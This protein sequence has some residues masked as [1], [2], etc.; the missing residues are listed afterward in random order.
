MIQQQV[1]K[2]GNS[3]V[4]TIPKSEM[5]RLGIKEG[6]MVALDITALELKPVL[7]PEIAQ[8][9]SEIREDSVPVMQYLRDK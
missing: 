1:R 4:V 8:V 6:Q 3:F 2:S 7:P 9:V 5:E